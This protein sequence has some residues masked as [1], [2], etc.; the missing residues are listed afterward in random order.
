MVRREILGR[1]DTATQP[2]TDVSP[3][4][5]QL[6]ISGIPRPN[7]KG[8]SDKPLLKRGG[9]SGAFGHV[10]ALL[11]CAPFLVLFVE[12][13]PFLILNIVHAMHLLLSIVHAFAFTS[14][15]GPVSL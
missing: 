10:L 15:F 11:P 4:D 13:A 3:I 2:E 5:S 8:S 1:R 6:K 14:L 7:R 9:G 12:W